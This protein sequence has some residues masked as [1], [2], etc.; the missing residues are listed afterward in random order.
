MDITVTDAQLV[1]SPGAQPNMWMLGLEIVGDDGTTRPWALAMPEDILEWRSA[2]TG[3]ED[4]GELL[5]LILFGTQVDADAS[6]EIAAADS[7]PEHAARLRAAVATRRGSGA[8]RDRNPQAGQGRVAGRGLTVLADVADEPE[9]PL[10]LLRKRLAP[11]PLRMRV[12]AEH[13]A[14]TRAARAARPVVDPAERPSA[15]DL[16]RR[17]LRH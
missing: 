9:T 14:R 10:P 17:L 4:P 16:Y 13:V 3:I 12:L 5:E 11:N 6:Q 7:P 8:L 15:T 1:A 2:E